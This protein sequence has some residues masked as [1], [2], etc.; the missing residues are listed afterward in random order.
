M[1]AMASQITGLTIGY[2]TIYSGTGERKHQSSV[3]LAF[4]R[5][6]HRWPVN[7]PHKWSV[8]RRKCSFDDVIMMSLK[9]NCNSTYTYWVA[10]INSPPWTKKAGTLLSID[11][12]YFLEILMQYHSMVFYLRC[13]LTP[14]VNKCWHSSA[15]RKS[16]SLRHHALTHLTQDKMAAIPQTIFSYAFSLMKSLIFLIEISL[17]FV[18]AGQTDNNPALV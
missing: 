13:V 8:T 14:N 11:S 4:V 17:M 6:I 12:K 3:S 2:S 7:S 15:I 9:Q 5:G 18:P 1:T 10:L 16:A